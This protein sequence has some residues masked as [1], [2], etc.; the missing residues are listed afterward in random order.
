M[1]HHFSHA[2]QLLYFVVGHLVVLTAPRQAGTR[3]PF[4][5]WRNPTHGI[6]AS[7]TMTADRT[8]VELELNP[9]PDAD[10]REVCEAAKLLVLVA[11]R[12]G[13]PIRL[14]APMSACDQLLGLRR[15]SDGSLIADA[16]DWL[17]PSRVVPNLDALY[18][19]SHLVP[20]Q[21]LPLCWDLLDPLLSESA[22]PGMRILEIGCGFGRNIRE[23][24]TSGAD[25]WG[26]DVARAAIARART[27][28]PRADRLLVAAAE[29]LPFAD[30]A[31]D[32]V[33]DVQCLHCLEPSGALLPALN[34]AARVLK[35]G[36][37]LYSRFYTPRDTSF[38][39]R[40]PLQFPRFGLPP[41]AVAAAVGSVHLTTDRMWSVPGATCLI[42][43]KP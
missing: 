30:E 13:P 32:A 40:Q 14:I 7:A 22:A 16:A 34:E 6:C 19:D 8:V 42:A 38:L 28:V 23:I 17:R 21:F 1:E 5:V 20:W 26:I 37:R 35:P 39:D 33:A 4:T 31:F 36:G 24:Q 9:A 15:C 3:H 18:R 43:S 25:I 11:A 2:L 12:L 29:A 27:W 10:L 41:E